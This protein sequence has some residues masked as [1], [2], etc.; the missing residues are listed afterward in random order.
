[1]KYDFSHWEGKLPKI[2]F[3]CITYARP[4]LL[5]EA[6]QCFLLQDYPGEKEMVILNDHPEIIVKPHPSIDIP[7]IKFVNLPE[8][9]ATIGEKRNICCEMCTG[10][11]IMPQDD[12]DISLP[13]R[14]S[15]S[16][17][18]M[19]NKHYFKPERYI[20]LRRGVIS[21]VQKNVAHAMGAF[22][23]ELWIK[24]GKYAVMQSGQDQTMENAF[25]KTGMRD[26]RSIKNEELFY[27]YRWSSTGSYHLSTYGWNRGFANCASFVKKKQIKSGEYIIKPNWKNA[28]DKLYISYIPRVRDHVPKPRTV[29]MKRR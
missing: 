20:K 16:M 12:D 3:Q 19:R 8:R 10:D 11:I 4:T 26:V 2:S 21:G 22:S 14:M 9:V 15:V 18:Y 5:A 7:T 17:Q 13:W 24:A 6:I 28:Y 23:K 27:I 1:M 29:S 25:K